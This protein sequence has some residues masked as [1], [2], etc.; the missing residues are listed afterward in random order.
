MTDVLTG[1]DFSMNDFSGKVV[2]METM[3]EWCSTCLQQQIEV[4]KLQGLINNSKDVV[5]VSLDT[6][7][8]E[9][10]A[11]LKEYAAT[12][13]F[14]WY[15]AVAPLE[16]DRAPG[17]LYSAEFMNPPFAPMLFIDRQGGVHV[18]PFGIKKAEALQSALT[19]YLAP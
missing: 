7:F 14:D 11:S 15:F 6:D 4:K 18:L 17:N 9:D 10:A 13:G 1:Q 5:H 12:W 16:V 2:L 8:H 3:A 19:P